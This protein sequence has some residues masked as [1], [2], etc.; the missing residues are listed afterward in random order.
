VSKNE[1]IDSK[2]NKKT[3]TSTKE[4]GTE[5][6][7]E[8]TAE[9]GSMELDKKLDLDSEVV[10]EEAHAE[11]KVEVKEESSESEGEGWDQIAE[12]DQK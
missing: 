9:G 11:L 7:K 1:R 4:I 6:E 5:E 12:R 10:V 8:P 2:R 3:E